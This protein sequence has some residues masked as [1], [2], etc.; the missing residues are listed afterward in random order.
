ME[1]HN[2]LYIITDTKFDDIYHI[3]IEFNEMTEILSR[4]KNVN[5]RFIIEIYNEKMY[6]F[7]KEKKYPFKYFMFTLYK[8]W[9]DRNYTDLENIFYFCVKNKIKGIIM[10]T[11]LFNSRIDTFSKKYSIPV[12]LHTENNL[13]RIVKFLENVRGIFSD[14]VDKYTLDTYLLNST[15]I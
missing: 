15:K 12:Y 2:D 5:E 10:Y 8:R 13:N 3:Q 1:Q 11:Y 9:L 14:E 6:S 7:L 4:H